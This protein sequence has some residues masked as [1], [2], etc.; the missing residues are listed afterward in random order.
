MRRMCVT[1]W[2]RVCFVF[3]LCL[4]CFLSCEV[5]DRGFWL[6]RESILLQGSE[7]LFR[8]PFSTPAPIQT[9]AKGG[10]NRY[11]VTDEIVFSRISGVDDHQFPS[12]ASRALSEGRPLQNGRL[13]LCA[14]PPS[15]RSWDQLVG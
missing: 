10:Q 8:L 5:S 2:V 15:V 11:T 3:F 1:A 7:Y 6:T 9:C 14:P 12:E 4:R 13:D